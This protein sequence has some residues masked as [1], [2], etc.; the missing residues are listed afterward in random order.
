MA[1]LEITIHPRIRRVDGR[2][3]RASQL[4]SG[5]VQGGDV[6]GI[7]LESTFDTTKEALTSPVSL[8][9]MSASWAGY[10]SVLR[11]DIDYWYPSFKSLVFDERL[12][13][14]KRP[15]VEVPV[16]AF[17]MLSSVTDSSQLLHNDHVAFFKG[18]HKLP[19]DLMQNSTNPSPLSSAQPAQFIFFKFSIKV[20]GSSFIQP[21]QNLLCLFPCY[22]DII[23]LTIGTFIYIYP[24]SA[25]RFD[26]FSQR[27]KKLTGAKNFP[28]N[29]TAFCI[30]YTPIAITIPQKY[31]VGENLLEYWEI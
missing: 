14:A 13:P 17:P 22:L 12:E 5:E 18:I 6:V 8:I 29:Q 19:A 24:N 10:G 31:M 25:F 20:N 26:Y 21:T 23:V 15:A 7:M 28:P 27:F 2:P 30:E 16:L 11:R 1:H 9:D 4:D 3:S